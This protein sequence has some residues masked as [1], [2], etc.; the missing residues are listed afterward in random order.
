MTEKYI[1]A[2]FHSL[3]FVTA[4]S[5]YQCSCRLAPFL[6]ESSVKMCVYKL[7]LLK[8]SKWET[9]EELGRGRRWHTHSGFRALS[10]LFPPTRLLLPQRSALFIPWLHSNLCSNNTLSKMPFLTTLPKITNTYHYSALT[11]YLTPDLL[12][13]FGLLTCVQG[14]CLIHCCTFKHWQAHGSW[15]SINT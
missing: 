11:L 9:V 4:Y 15:Y 10:L 2:R 13:E 12:V 7:T 6:G 8:R 1:L 3:L 5:F 14:L